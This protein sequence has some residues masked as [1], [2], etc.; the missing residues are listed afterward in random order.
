[1]ILFL[2]SLALAVQATSEMCVVRYD[3][4]DPNCE[5]DMWISIYDDIWTKDCVV[6]GWGSGRA[7][8]TSDDDIMMYGYGNDNKYNS[9]P[10]TGT[11]VNQCMTHEIFYDWYKKYKCVPCEDLVAQAKD[12][13]DCSMVYKDETPLNP[14]CMGIADTHLCMDVG[15]NN[16][17]CFFEEYCQGPSGAC[18]TSEGMGKCYNAQVDRYGGSCYRVDCTAG[19]LGSECS[20]C[21][22]YDWMY[23]M[24]GLSGE[25]Q[26]VAS[27]GIGRCWQSES[28]LGTPFCA[29]A[30]PLLTTT[31][32]PEPSLPPATS[33][34]TPIPTENPITSSPTESPTAQPT[35]SQPTTP[36]PTP[37]PTAQPTTSM[38][39]IYPSL[40]PTLSPEK[41][42]GW[43]SRFRN[44]K[45]RS[46]GEL[47]SESALQSETSPQSS[48]FENDMF[49]I[50]IQFF[51]FIGLVTSLY[52]ASSK[53][54]AAFTR[55]SSF[56]QIGQDEEI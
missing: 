43:F 52:W 27:D 34:P 11:L 28:T 24:E 55:N 4:K 20:G 26:C 49:H 51:A 2:F 10:E 42:D 37:T 25:T 30:E 45:R 17:T 33:V 38:P 53:I 50:I 39:T 6:F 5:K 31:T 23:G 46:S 9:C 56:S 35:T 12:E 8:C 44:R 18:I 21:K 48:L 19:P 22:T 16:D 13:E 3:S 14:D 32:T 40:N 41:D 36:I 7:T 15:F 47:E 29:T 1:M 54:K